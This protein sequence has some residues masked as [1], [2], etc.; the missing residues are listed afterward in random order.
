MDSR[1]RPMV[2]ERPRQKFRLQNQRRAVGNGWLIYCVLS[3]ALLLCLG[4]LGLNLPNW[5]IYVA[6]PRVDR[7]CHRTDTMGRRDFPRHGLRCELL[8]RN[9]RPADFGVVRLMAALWSDGGQDGKDASVDLATRGM[10]RSP[11]HRRPGGC[12]SPKLYRYNLLP[13]RASVFRIRRPFD[14]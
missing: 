3:S 6:D 2:E 4:W 8:S 5:A 9:S 1:G 11:I 13:S 10:Y 7:Q 14:F 12:S